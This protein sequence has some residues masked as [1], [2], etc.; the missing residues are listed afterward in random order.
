M[1]GWGSLSQAARGT[2]RALPWSSLLCL[3]PSPAWR[4]P[5]AQEVRSGGLA[6]P[7]APGTQGAGAVGCSGGSAALWD[8]QCCGVGMPSAMADLEQ[9]EAVQLK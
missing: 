7:S 2:S 4:Q 5:L 3:P 6:L 1:Q 9:G 8:W